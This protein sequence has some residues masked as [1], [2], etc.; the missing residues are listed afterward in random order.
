MLTIEKKPVLGI[1][2]LQKSAPDFAAPQIK[3]CQT[4]EAI[5]HHW[6]A[7]FLGSVI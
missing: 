7:F 4:H 3:Y 2:E 6:G 5:S 1:L